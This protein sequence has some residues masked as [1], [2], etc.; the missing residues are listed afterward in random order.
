MTPERWQRIDAILPEA[1]ERPPAERAAFLAAAC[2]GDD[3]LRHELESLLGFQQRAENFIEAPPGELAADWLAGEDSRTGLTLGHYQLLRQLG[4]GGMGVVYL[5]HDRRL[6]RQVALKLLPAR[7]TQ[8]AARLSRFRQEARA[9]SALNHPNILTIYEIGAAAGVHFIATEFVAGQ[10]LRALLKAGQLTLGAALEI[11]R[12]TAQA[13]AAAHRAGIVHRDIKPENL[14]QRADGY[15]KVLDFGLAKLTDTTAAGPSYDTTTSSALRTQP[16]AVLGT[17]TY[18]SPEQARGLEVDGGAD[19]FSLGVVLYELLTG[20][21]PFAGETPSDALAALLTQEPAPLAAHLPGLPAGLQPIVQR[22]LQKRRADRYRDADEFGAAL[23]ALKQEL[24]A[25]V[26]RPSQAAY[27]EMFVGQA[28]AQDERLTYQTTAQPIRPTKQSLIHLFGGTRRRVWVVALVVLLSLSGWL[29]YRAGGWRN[30]GTAL[31]WGG[32]QAAQLRWESEQPSVAVLPFADQTHDAQLQDLPDGLTDGLINQ[33]ALLPDL[34]VLSGAAVF[35]YKGRAAAPMQVGQDL[36]VRAVVSGRVQAQAGELLVNVE[37]TD[38][39]DGTRLWGKQYQRPLAEVQTLPT[40]LAR[41][42]AQQLSLRPNDPS[43]P[44]FAKSYT[45]D[46]AAY[47]L[48]LQ[49]SYQWNKRTPDGL[50][51]ALALFQ[52]A[53]EKDPAYALAYVGLADAYITLGTYHVRPPGEVYPAAREA[54]TQA[55]RIDEGLAGAHTALGKIISDYYW[56]W[57][58]AEKEFQRALSLNA[59]SATAHGWYASWLENVGRLNEAVHETQ[60][61]LQLDPLSPVA[62]TEAAVALY[63]ARRYGEAQ[64]LLQQ[65]LSREPNYLTARI[66]LGFCYRLLGQY[67]ASRNEFQKGLALAPQSASLIGLYGSACGLAG[68]RDDALQALAQLNKMAQHTYVP[69][70][71][72]AGVTVGLGDVDATFDW[73]AKCLAERSPVLGGLKTDPMFDPVRADARFA[74]LLQ[75]VGFQ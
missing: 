6:R 25:P 28:Q 49:G 14:M 33:L 67:E 50:R 8:D 22:A 34:R 51:Q 23:A 64:A 55:L 59:N 20:R 37:L 35:T 26:Q 7:Y 39:R 52:Q 54:V 75:Q 21:V 71:A 58:Q 40:A 32:G 41:D 30:W 72:Q 73:L 16:G 12:Q 57:P 65:T 29:F 42:V 15:V 56:D 10:T 9:A 17:L 61:A 69:P 47:R 19:L 48:Y 44:E 70:I 38:T 3:D 31:R 46:P 74:A 18:M 66:Y 2:A 45:T 60:L 68:H 11:V 27:L 36:K 53:V 63:R 13:L 5:A 43:H 4:R 24:A 62:N 1:L